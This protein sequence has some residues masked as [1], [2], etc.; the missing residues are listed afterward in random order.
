LSRSEAVG[1]EAGQLV[2]YC[3]PGY[4]PNTV[5]DAFTEETGIV[6]FREFYNS[7]EELLRH[8]LVNRRYDLVQPSDYAVD[9]LIKRG[10]LEPVRPERIPNLKNLD[11]RFRNLQYDPGGTY[12]V[13]WLAGTVG[14]VINTRK[15]SEP[16][17]GYGDV[18][19]GNYRGRI[20]ALSDAREWL[21]WALCYLGLPVN[22]V[23]PSV[24]EKVR[25]VWEEWI[26]QVAIFD[27]DAAADVMLDGRADLALTWSGDAASLLSKSSAY[28]FVLPREGAHQY[29]DSLAVPLG[30]PNRDQAESFIDFILRP[31]ISV[32]ISN[33]IPFTNPN[34][35]AFE[36][37]TDK[38]KSN[39]ASYPQG[40]PDLRSFR[41][42]GDMVDEVEALFNELRFNRE[43]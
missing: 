13:P 24:L 29:V 9:A 43:S 32:M 31:E 23:T 4:V 12:S 6:V 1:D 30:A 17:Q 25:G 11:P 26:P 14:I 40:N 7:N 5:I 37:L 33:A 18:F 21:G 19:S 2:I 42:I 16:V 10:A 41:E 27:S 34:Q 3:W 15:I 39:P 35:A 22:E 8:R 38:Q 28:S 20:V 36:R